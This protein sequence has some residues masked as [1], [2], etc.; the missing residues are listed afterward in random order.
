MR[1]HNNCYVTISAFSLI[2]LKITLLKSIGQFERKFNVIFEAPNV[3]SKY[4]TKQSKRSIVTFQALI[5]D[6]KTAFNFL[7]MRD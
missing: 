6:N 1:V 4:I 7:E 5:K 3:L 2:H